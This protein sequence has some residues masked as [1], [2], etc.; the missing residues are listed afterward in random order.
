MIVPSKKAHALCVWVSPSTSNEA[1]SSANN[2]FD[3][4][5]AFFPFCFLNQESLQINI[6]KVK[7]VN[8]DWAAACALSRSHTASSARVLGLNWVSV[9]PNRTLVSWW[10]GHD[11]RETGFQSDDG[12]REWALGALR[13]TVTTILQGVI[14]YYSSNTR[15]H[16]IVGC[17][18]IKA[19]LLWCLQDQ[20][21]KSLRSPKH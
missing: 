8:S 13:A 1:L 17:F 10:C 3:W 16:N 20:R 5:Y 15:L 7:A 9:Q 11:R 21:S 18:M 12:A 14:Y 6:R 2:C 19:P 4:P